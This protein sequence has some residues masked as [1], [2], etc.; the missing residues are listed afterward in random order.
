MENQ[1]SDT[2]RFLSTGVPGLDTILS[3]GLSSDRLYL[4]EGDPGTGKTTLALQ[5]LYEGVR[6]GES[7]VYITLAETRVELTSVASSHGWSMD[8]IHVGDII[9]DENIL[10]PEQ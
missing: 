5:F 6:Q 10:H 3:G 8:G 2:T 4:I 1:N 7:V 9:P